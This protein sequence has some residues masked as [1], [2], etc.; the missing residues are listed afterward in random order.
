MRTGEGF[1]AV[2]RT[3]CERTT[4]TVFGE[5]DIATG[6]LLQDALD[7]ALATGT[8]RIDVDFSH[9][10][11]CDCAGLAVLLRARADARARGIRLGVSQVGIPWVRNLFTTTGTD[12]LLADGPAAA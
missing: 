9:V 4:V 11:F 7:K 3:A 10:T 12:T 6:P 1:R 5:I 2:T 8:P